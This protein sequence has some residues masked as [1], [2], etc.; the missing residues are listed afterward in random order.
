[1][2]KAYWVVTYRSIKNPDALQ[3]Y[4]KIAG[5]ALTAAGGRILVRGTPAKIYEAGMD[6]R[7]VLIEFDS[8]AQAIAAHDGP[9]YKHALDLLGKD[10]VVRDVRILEGLA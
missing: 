5:P 10:N 3:A 4:G 9:A 7:T 6:Q 1:M 8:L 2:P